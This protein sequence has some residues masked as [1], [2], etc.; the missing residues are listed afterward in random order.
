MSEMTEYQLPEIVRTSLESLCLQVCVCVAVWFELGPI[1]GS[2]FCPPPPPLLP[3]LPP[4][5]VCRNHAVFF[6]FKF[7]GRS[8]SFPPTLV[9]DGFS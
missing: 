6:F 7:Y 8:D 3:L 5:L 4:S 1:W 2:C 9:F